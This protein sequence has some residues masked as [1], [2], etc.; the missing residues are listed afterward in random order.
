MPNDWVTRWANESA[1]TE[2]PDEMLAITPLLREMQSDTIVVQSNS[3]VSNRL[4]EYELLKDVATTIMGHVQLARH[5]K[6]KRLV[7]LKH[8]PRQ[9]S[10]ERERARLEYEAEIIARLKHE[11]IVTLYDCFEYR[12][13]PLLVLEWVDGGNL[14]DFVKARGRL[15]WRE[16]LELL[17][18]LADAMQ[19]AHS[20]RVIHRDLKPNNVL[21]TSAGKLKISDFGLST[22]QESQHQTTLPHGVGTPAFMA[23]EQAHSPELV[24]HLADQ[25]ALGAIGY[26]LLTG[27]SI[28]SSDDNVTRDATFLPPMELHWPE[29]LPADFQAILLKCLQI[30]PGLRYQNTADLA[31]DLALLRA[32]KPVMARP[33]GVL[34]R[35]GKLVRRNPM[36]TTL[37]SLI[38]AIV[39][40]SAIWLALLYRQTVIIF[41]E[42]VGGLRAVNAASNTDT[43]GFSQTKWIQLEMQLHVMEQYLNY[44]QRPGAVDREEVMQVIINTGA[45]MWELDLR[46]E[47]RICLA[48]IV[49]H[50]LVTDLPRLS[51]EALNRWVY[52]QALCDSDTSFREIGLIQAFDKQAQFIREKRLN[53]DSDERVI[54]Q[55]L[56]TACALGR[57]Y[58]E[59]RQHE[60]AVPVY[61][62]AWEL[63]DT[64]TYQS[65]LTHL[66]RARVLVEGARSLLA[67]GA[68]HNLARWI[69]AGNAFFAQD[70]QDESLLIGFAE[71]VVEWEITHA[72]F[73]SRQQSPSA[74]KVLTELEGIQ[75]FRKIVDLNFPRREELL[76]E[77]CLLRAQLLVRS[78]GLDSSTES[79]LDT[80]EQ[81][82]RR[83][84]EKN[85]PP[86]LGKV[87]LLRMELAVL[88]QEPHRALEL[89][90]NWH[91][92]ENDLYQLT[93]EEKSLSLLLLSRLI[94]Q[95]SPE[96]REL[97]HHECRHWIEKL[98]TPLPGST[99][100][101]A[102]AIPREVRDAWH[103]IVTIA[104][105][106]TT[107]EAEIARYWIQLSGGR[108][109]SLREHPASPRLQYIVEF[110]QA[111]YLGSQLSMEKC[112]QQPPSCEDAVL[113]QLY[114]E[115]CGKA[116]RQPY[117]TLSPP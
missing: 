50:G 41:N 94:P 90:N 59:L 45:T 14:E 63:L 35:F 75:R 80:C 99:A 5:C 21:V 109:A 74:L 67:A 64:K 9:V 1:A 98:P 103:W 60:K 32:G 107:S 48:L 104:P 25:F 30:E 26:F 28:R 97:L 89:L 22:L 95:A 102:L 53:G 92:I 7:A 108:A 84:P 72:R 23:P 56:Q 111:S 78:F 37:I 100:L 65:P 105:S 93:A 88:R 73:L 101:A 20:E 86:W 15:P 81:A 115:L 40:L 18:I 44:L 57:H 87:L 46:N 4:A 12:G 19:Y 34:S 113:H 70:R 3:P 82:V 117:R 39:L 62:A 85:Q 6:T 31:R 16:A 116:T 51:P 110:L 106:D 2:Q 83:M 47:A 61:L 66:L 10:S 8:L 114:L 91:Q 38:L 29:K 68:M 112:L 24:N 77:T 55:Y 71:Y 27:Q 79:V 33:I 17:I 54:Q 69:E 43:G 58:S 11:N 36:I 76:A 49:S 96:W 52:Y 42:A 13:S